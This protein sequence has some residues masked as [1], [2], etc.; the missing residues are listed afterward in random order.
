M[1]NERWGKMFLCFDSN[2]NMSRYLL[3]LRNLLRVFNV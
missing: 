2:S 3:E 1:F